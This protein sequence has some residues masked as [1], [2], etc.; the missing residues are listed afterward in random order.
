MTTF[1]CHPSS[2]IERNVKIGS[3]TNIW[4][5]S[6]IDEGAIIGEYT[7]LGQNTYIGKNVIVGNHVKVQNNVSIYQGVELQ[8]YAFCGPSV[9]FTNDLSPRSQF[10]K[11]KALF[12]KT[13]VEKNATIGANSTIICGITI[14]QNSMIGAGSVV[15]KSV[16]P[17]ELVYGNPASHKGW[18]CECGTR[19]E[20]SLNCRYCSREYEMTENGLLRISV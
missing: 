7:N 19:L 10:P 14:G 20:S 16:L 3:N 4:H 18:V 1:Y 6:H 15:T 9:V 2:I 12:V 17:H 5:F 8:D 11:G 13:I